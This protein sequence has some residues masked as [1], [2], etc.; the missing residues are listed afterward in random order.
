MA[1]VSKDSLGDFWR[2]VISGDNVSFPSSQRMIDVSTWGY[3]D[4]DNDHFINHDE[5]E[6]AFEGTSILGCQA[7]NSECLPFRDGW[8]CVGLPKHDK[9]VQRLSLGCLNHEF[10]MPWNGFGNKRQH[11]TPMV[12]VVVKSFGVFK[13]CNPKITL[14]PRRFISKTVPKSSMENAGF[15]EE[16]PPWG[17]CSM[18]VF[19][20]VMSFYPPIN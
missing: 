1:P 8:G 9:K 12:F 15:Q 18:L 11:S 16:S 10:N 5:F 6:A 20:S 14:E 13:V 3:M 19:G 7:F 4:L 17:P 2:E